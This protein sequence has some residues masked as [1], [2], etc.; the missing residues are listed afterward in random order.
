MNTAARTL[1]GVAAGVVVSVG[2]LLA[3]AAIGERTAPR[4]VPEDASGTLERIAIHYTPAMD[5]EALPVWRQLFGVLPPTIRVAVAVERADD[6]TAFVAAMRDARVAHLERFEASVVGQP[7]TTWSRDRMAAVESPAGVIA[8]PQVA[9]ASR[10]RAGDWQA[11]FAIA[12]QVYGESPQVTNFVF[13]GGDFAASRGY[14]FADVNLTARNLGRGDASP[15]HLQQAVAHTF[16]QQ[17]IWLGDHLGDVPE[18]HIMMYMVPL[19]DRQVVV[20]DPRWGAAL[21]PDRQLD[22]DHSAARFDRVAGE[23]A[24]RGFIVHRIP[25]IVLPGAGSYITYTNALFDRSERGG[26][27]Q[28]IVY[29]PI[30]GV[31]QLDDVAQQTYRALGYQVIPIDVSTIYRRN[32]S[33]GC[34]VNVMARSY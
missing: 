22:T 18:H 33:L 3:E 27:S 11:P 32:G 24:A 31:P 6:F 5:R 30:Y 14:L 7:I 16:G 8:P 29:L 15:A 9:T 13:E 1:I 28:S 4:L 34:L 23:L 25:V 26:P 21:A 17:L 20:G 2:V 19:D 10:H 12:R